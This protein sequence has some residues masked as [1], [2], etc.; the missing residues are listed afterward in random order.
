MEHN[1]IIP[2]QCGVIQKKSNDPFALSIR[3]IRVS[4]ELWKMSSQGKNRLTLLII[5]YL[6]VLLTLMIIFLLS[7]RQQPQ[8]FIPVGFQRISN[9]SVI[10]I[11]P[12]VTAS[13]QF[14]FI[15]RTL[16]LLS[17]EIVGF[18]QTRL[19]FLLNRQGHFECNWRDCLHKNIAYRLVDVGS[20]D[21][22]AERL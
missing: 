2:K 15:T 10:G 21:V 22:L 5:D 20:R 16:N 11:D 8:F 7:R 13:G 9:Q 4:P 1:L 3:R 12:E 18:I 14:R 19:K 6:A 17:P